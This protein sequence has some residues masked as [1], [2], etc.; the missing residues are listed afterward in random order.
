MLFDF[1][2]KLEIYTP[3]QERRWGYYV[4]PFLMDDRLVARFDLKTDRVG[5]ILEVRTAHVEPGAAAVEVAS[6]AARELEKLARLVGVDRVRVGPRGN[7]AR[8]LSRELAA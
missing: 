7:L 6:R 2:Y 1:E 3:A 4:L 5:R 8:K